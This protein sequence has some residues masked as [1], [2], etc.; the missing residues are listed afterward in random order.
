[1][2][3]GSRVRVAVVDSGVH[4]GHPHIGQIAGGVSIM[5]DGNMLD[6]G[7]AWLDR[8]GH[9]TAVT[10]AIQEKA[11][12]ADYVAVRVFHTGLRA[13]TA[14]LIR[15]IDWCIDREIDVVN[16]SLGSVSPA[17]GPTF[18]HAADRAQAAGLILVA[19][20]SANDEPCYPGCLPNVISVA[21]DWECPRD[22][23][24]VEQRNGETIFSASGYPRP[25]PGVPP[26]R[27]LWGIS[28]AVANM[29]GFVAHRCVRRPLPRAGGRTDAIK[30]ALEADAGQRASTVTADPG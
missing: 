30:A 3:E 10:A 15:A 4:P 9:G 20:R 7:A 11:P 16:L 21:L 26:A 25:A 23:Y 28:F 8:L 5:P 19:A 14:T 24:R 12:D 1:M 18:R 29:S 2:P 17:S 22:E 27:N 6:D 13:T